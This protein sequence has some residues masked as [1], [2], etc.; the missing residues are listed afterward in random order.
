MRAALEG[1]GQRLEEGHGGA[2][3]KVLFVRCTDNLLSVSRFNIA[4]GQ[5]C[6]D[7]GQLK[8]SLFKTNRPAFRVGPLPADLINR[9]LNTELDA[10]DVWVSKACHSHIADDHPDDYPVIMAN[11]IDVLRSP[12]YAGQDA[13]AGGGFYLVKKVEPGVAGREFALVVIAMEQNQFGTYNVKSAYT[14]KQSDV[15]SRRMKGALRVLF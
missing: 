1:S 2:F 5:R 3:R 15:D 11:L 13:H 4:F 12:T 9:A 6:E 10:A 7:L 14:I 8:R